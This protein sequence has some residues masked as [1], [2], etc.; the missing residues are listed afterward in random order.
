MEPKRTL[1]VRMPI[2]LHG[3]LK[4]LAHEN[5]CSMEAVVRALIEQAILESIMKLEAR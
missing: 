2:A 3:G 5:K 4:K 1:T